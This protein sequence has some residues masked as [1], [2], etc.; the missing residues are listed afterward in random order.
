MRFLSGEILKD[1]FK[2]KLFSHLFVTFLRRKIWT[3]WGQIVSYLTPPSNSIEQKLTEDNNAKVFLDF[4][5]KYVGS[6]YC[7]ALGNMPL[8]ANWNSVFDGLL[9]IKTSYP[10]ALSTYKN[11][12]SS[13]SD[14]QTFAVLGGLKITEKR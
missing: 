6:Y 12:D 3:C 2:N 7:S 1:H 10:P 14:S 4:N 5:K 13:I 9:F 11:M 8:K